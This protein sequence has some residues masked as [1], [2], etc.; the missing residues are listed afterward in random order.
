[1]Y[2]S[3]F[4]EGSCA[5]EKL[6]FFSSLT[7]SQM[8]LSPWLKRPVS[9]DPLAGATASVTTDPDGTSSSSENSVSRSPI[10]M[11]ITSNDTV[12]DPSDQVSSLRLFSVLYNEFPAL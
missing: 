9:P 4:I 7:H 2:A 6:L 5:V 12:I 10:L 1:M 11:E 3:L 8:K